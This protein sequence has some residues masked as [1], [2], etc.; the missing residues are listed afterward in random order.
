MTGTV[1]ILGAKGRFGRAATQAFSTAGWEIRAAT[2]AGDT[3]TT[4]CITPVACDVMDRDAVI[5]A[6][7][8]VDVIVHAVHPAYPDWA[9]MMPV[10]TA[11]IIA[12]GLSSGA[13]VMIVGNV[14]VFGEEAAEV[15]DEANAFAPT[16]RKGA[17]RVTMEAAFEAATAQGLRSVV[18]RGG[19]FIERH[20]SGNWFDTYMTNKI[21]KGVF[22]YPGRTDAVHAWAYLPDMARAMVGLAAKRDTLPAFSSFGF[23]GYSLTGDAL[24]AAVARTVGRPL[25]SVSF[26]WWLLRVIGL[27]NPLVHEVNE[28]RYLWDRPHRLD[29]TALAHVLPDFVPTPLDRAMVEVLGDDVKVTPDQ[30]AHALRSA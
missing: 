4:A 19:D 6:A 10:H 13:T 11:N 7:H 23:E 14:Y 3:A 28:M 1:L 21:H 17:L 22:T 20:K 18:L 16:T 25:K 5:A 26:P 29:G 8:G 30:G 27:F 9:Q 15:Y 2:R 24:K 12:A